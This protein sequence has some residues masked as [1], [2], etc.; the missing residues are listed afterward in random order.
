[1]MSRVDPLPSRSPD[2]AE[3]SPVERDLA[4]RP[5]GARAVFLQDWWQAAASE[6]R[7]F[8]DVEAKLGGRRA[9][10]LRYVVHRNKIGA[11]L[12]IA[13]FWTHLGGPVLADGLS[14]E[15]QRKAVAEIA[16]QLPRTV[17]FRF[18]CDPSTPYAGLV[19][20]EFEKVGFECEQHP[21]YLQYPDDVGVL[22]R[23]KGRHR[24]QIKA[25]MKKTDVEDGSPDEFIAFYERNLET[26]AH[27]PLPIA[28]RLLRAGVAAGQV[29]IFFA[30]NRAGAEGLDRI[31]AAIACA[32]DGQRYYYWLSRRRSERAET[33]HLP[34]PNREATKILVLAAIDH[35]RELGLVFDADSPET[36][37]GRTLFSVLFG[38]QRIEYRD[39]L[40]R[41]TALT[42]LYDSAIP[43]L[44][45]LIKTVHPNS[46]LYTP[47]IERPR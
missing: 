46:T 22:E 15:D 10:W 29:R 25:A 2:P 39:V 28:H 44:K 19:R 23:M 20:E 42:R 41:R 13:P 4:A 12:G 14:P 38:F 37:G 26:R 33:P 6:G 5:E 36:I 45:R 9:G 8:F 32:W 24:T 17:S 40:V 3:D 7:P 16:R 30:C 43:S 34:P 18:M 31:D 21:N 47:D 35:A 27:S 11:R 1:M